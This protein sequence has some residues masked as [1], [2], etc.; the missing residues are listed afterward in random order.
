MELFIGTKEDKLRHCSDYIR[1]DLAP[2]V[3]VPSLSPVLIIC[4][5][6]LV[7]NWYEEL[8]MWAYFKVLKMTSNNR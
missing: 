2:G 5:A 8:T 7:E 6:S 3:E 4:P 1:N